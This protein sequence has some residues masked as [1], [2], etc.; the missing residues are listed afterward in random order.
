MSSGS[1]RKNS[2]RDATSGRITFRKEPRAFRFTDDRVYAEQRKGPVHPVTSEARPYHTQA[3]PEPDQSGHYTLV[4]GANEVFFSP[5][6]TLACV[7]A[8]GS[9]DSWNQLRTFS[10]IRHVKRR[11]DTL[12]WPVWVTGTKG[13]LD[14][15]LCL[16]ARKNRQH[17]FALMVDGGA[18]VSQI[19]SCGAGGRDRYAMSCSI[20]G[21]SAG[22]H[23]IE[24]QV[25]DADVDELI[26]LVVRSPELILAVRER[27]RPEAAHSEFGTGDKRACDA[28][29]AQLQQVPPAD[30]Q[31]LSAFS[32]L[33]TPFGY[34]GP[35]IN[36]AGVATGI[37]FSFWSYGRGQP[38]PPLHH[39]SKIVAI[40]SA[41]PEVRFGRFDH[42]GHGVKIRGFN[43]FASNSSKVY[44]VALKFAKVSEH[45]D[46]F[47]YS[48]SS[49]YWDEDA[50]VR[51]ETAV[52]S[53][54]SSGSS[55]SSK[56][57]AAATPTKEGVDADPALS[58]VGSD[59]ERDLQENADPFAD[60]EN[61]E[62]A[63]ESGRLFDPDYDD[64]DTAPGQWCLYGV[65]L[66]YRKT[67]IR[68]LALRGFV[69]VPG[70]AEK[71]R[72]NHVRRSVGYRAYM[73]DAA[74]AKR[75]SNG[76][77]SSS[78]SGS[79]L[80]DAG[81]DAWLPVTVMTGNPGRTVATT[82]KRWAT[83]ENREEY[84][85]VASCGGLRQTTAKTMTCKLSPRVPEQEALPLYMQRIAQI[86]EP[87]P[88]PRV[89]GHEIV[90]D[91]ENPAKQIVQTIRLELGTAGPAFHATGAGA[92][93]AVRIE[94]HYGPK[95]G[96]CLRESWAHCRILTV[97]GVGGGGW[98]EVAVSRGRSKPIPATDKLRVMA[99]YSNLQVWALET[100]VP[101]G[102]VP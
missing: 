74:A 62:A 65:G 60:P 6:G 40:G 39:Q 30:G 55:S 17:T 52:H 43:P 15:D 27:W 73:R 98:A 61:M 22:F 75:G 64:H 5:P 91:P 99:V 82:N 76:G 35:V 9:R 79:R 47:V 45:A 96:Q 71:Q 16:R 26:A 12:V 37:N 8:G 36:A 84:D 28:W 44:A 56:A 87:V 20:Y 50:D 7:R 34:Y 51:P 49:Y 25:R 10:H 31:A 57:A 92:D 67:A 23:T 100:Y 93:S 24:L 11:G 90:V 32:P 86:D 4:L 69:E 102:E 2:E 77:A 66:K 101:S 53:S 1:S 70:R 58:S 19:F 68:T 41:A 72:T 63:W 81:G 29:V 54:S 13:F 21:L 59:R 46:G 88:F 38:A 78:R 14:M 18:R 3:C 33:T 80:N 89:V 97:P 83:A 48:F 85:F 42:E 94:L 95:D